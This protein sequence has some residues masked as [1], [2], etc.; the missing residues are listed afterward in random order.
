M[1]KTQA[2]EKK[3]PP[4]Q[5]DALMK[6]L[7]ARFEQNAGRHPG[8]KWAAVE[9]RLEAKA[10]TLWSLHQ[11]ETSGGEPDVVGHDKDDR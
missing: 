10:Q 3:L 5:R 4:V 8:L 6:I 11:M 7:K 9:A 1:K 2:A